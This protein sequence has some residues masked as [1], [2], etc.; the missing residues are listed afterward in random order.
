MPVGEVDYPGRYADFLA[1]FGEAASCLGYLGEF[2][3]R[4]N[5]RRSRAPGILFYCLIQAA[6]SA[7]PATYRDNAQ[8]LV[9]KESRRAGRTGLPGKPRTLALPPL[10]RP[11]RQ[12]P[13]NG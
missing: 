6:T 7:P 4:F 11:W 12:G 10:D 3:F 9:T 1:W 8:S 13:P 2:A 5:R